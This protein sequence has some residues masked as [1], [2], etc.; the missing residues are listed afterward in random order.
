MLNGITIEN[1]KP[2]G[3]EQYARLA[4]ITLVYGPNSSGKSSLIQ[5]L[6]LMRQTLTEQGIRSKNDLI[7]SGAFTNLGSYLSL[8]HKHDQSRKLKV[9]FHFDERKDGRRLSP[10]PSFPC[11]SIQLI[12]S[13][14]TIAGNEVLPLLSEVE[15]CLQTGRKSEY[16]LK[17]ERAARNS[18]EAL[19]AKA[20]RTADEEI[21][22]SDLVSGNQ[23][24]S[25]QKLRDDDFKLS[26]SNDLLE[27]RDILIK[28]AR[29][30]WEL[31]RRRFPGR[32]Q[33]EFNKFTEQDSESPSLKEF[34]ALMDIRFR[35]NTVGPW[36]R[37]Y[38][39]VDTSMAYR[40]K[41]DIG[42][43]YS[44]S[45]FNGLLRRAGLRLNQEIG[46]LSYLGP[47][48]T[49]PER[50]YALQGLPEDSVGA[51]GE[52]AVQILY[53]DQQS[54]RRGS[55]LIDKLNE[56][57]KVFE[58][59]YQF[60]IRS[61]RDQITGHFLVLS[62]TDSRT[63]VEVAPTDVGFGI[64]QIL[65]VLVEGMVAQEA[66]SHPRIVCVEQPEI[67]LHP[68]LQAAMADF[69]IDTAFVDESSEDKERRKKQGV[70]WILETHSETLILRLQRRI[71]EGK[72]SNKSVCVLYVDPREEQGAVI[73]E[74]RLDEDG[75][76][77]D[78]WPDGF[79]A[80]SFN[81]IFGGD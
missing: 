33:D 80:D 40:S 7:T 32:Y 37:L 45:A 74:L 4:P 27:L 1:F 13:A 52:Q 51:Q 22:E 76:F 31:R 44:A 48:R 69:F 6:L 66:G 79:F 61:F 42:D 11:S 78:D 20:E 59:P 64:G 65:P 49:H 28:Q 25:K 46:T 38:L 9:A 30:E 12:Y 70:H 3:S 71:R 57:C 77:I 56:Y 2:F 26:S 15:F 36:G 54:Q 81:E 72:L 23:Y 68:R 62:L 14:T 73:E 34:E 24:R 67:H 55:S 17:L 21:E 29:E 41:E 18:S 8:V 39:P 53:H 43:N 60:D 75:E 16:K 5:A 35:A 47:L 58:I 19:R 10:S 63:G 50:L